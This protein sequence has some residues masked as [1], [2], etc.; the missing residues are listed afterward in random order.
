MLRV[1]HL[2]KGVLVCLAVLLI[3][4][5]WLHQRINGA[6]GRWPL[7]L[8]LVVLS[9]VSVAA[10]FDFGQYPKFRSFMNSH[11]MYHYYMGSKYSREVGYLYLYQCTLLADWELMNRPEEPR[12]PSVRRMDDYSFQSGKEIVR[13]AEKYSGRFTPERWEEFKLDCRYFATLLGGSRWKSV[14]GDMGYNAT[15]VWNMVARR[16]TNIVPTSSTFGMSLLVSFDLILIALMTALASWTFGWRNGL[17]ALIFFCT[18]FCMSYTHIRGGFLRLDWVAMLVMSL[19]LLKKARYKTAGALMGYAGMARIFPLVFA[20]GLGGKFL[21][22]FLRTR[23]LNRNYLAFFITFGAVCVILMS[24]SVWSD[25]GVQHWA[26]FSKKIS[27]HNNHFAPPRVGFR[28]I[29]LMAYDYPPG[30][31]PAYSKQAHKKLEDWWLLWLGIRGSAV[32]LVVYLVKNVEDY[33]TIPLGYVPAYFLTA[34]T[35]Y[36][37][38]MLVA[39]LFLFLPKRD[40]VQRLI[41]LLIVFLYSVVM[42]YVN[43]SLELDLRFVWFAFSMA[44]V[45]LVIVLYM[46]FTAA[47]ARAAPAPL[48]ITPEPPPVEPSPKASRGRKSRNK[49]RS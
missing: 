5:Y 49:R 31:W 8:A 18:C 34:P 47:I 20:V 23:K 15:P 45:L 17:L 39:A 14:V 2:V 4:G 29:F 22:D 16:I 3:L 32:L 11:D 46:L 37:H 1:L 44:C 21:W 9:L 13:D 26:E 41:G 43:R 6:R 30:G 12:I 33:E 38:V 36:Y 28:N 24:L 27:L 10:Y 35:F 19:C 25:G 48:P 42:F 7:D 40:Q